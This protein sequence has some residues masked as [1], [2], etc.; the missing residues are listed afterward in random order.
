[1]KKGFLVVLAFITIIHSKTYVYAGNILTTTESS[2]VIN[3]SQIMPR[4][5]VKEYKYRIHNG[6]LQR[7]LWSVTYGHWIDDNWTDV[8]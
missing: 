7:R 5:E 3:H 6:K 8:E 4:A 1:M 2:Q